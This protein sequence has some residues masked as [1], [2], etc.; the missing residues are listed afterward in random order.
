M[1]RDRQ[2]QN[3]LRSTAKTEGIA[4][5]GKSEQRDHMVEVQRPRRPNIRHFYTHA[6]SYRQTV[7]RHW[8]DER[9]YPETI[10]DSKSVRYYN[11]SGGSSNQASQYLSNPI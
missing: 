8:I 3:N 6:S 5:V 11:H 2:L 7:R 10:P 9:D 1:E 4:A